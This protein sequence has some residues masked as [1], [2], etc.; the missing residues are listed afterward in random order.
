GAGVTKRDRSGGDGGS[1]L[2]CFEAPRRHRAIQRHPIRGTIAR[3]RGD[4]A[5][6]AGRSR[7][8]ARRDDV[9]A[10]VEQRFD[11]DG[12]AFRSTASR[13][14]RWASGSPETASGLLPA[15]LFHYR[16]VYLIMPPIFLPIFARPPPFRSP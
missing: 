12:G 16:R 14:D 13:T 8:R 1:I 5:Q 3:Y 15:P 10:F 11:C 9:R 4:P 6:Y 2:S 7:Y